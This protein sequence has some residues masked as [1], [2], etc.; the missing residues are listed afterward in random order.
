MYQI[1]TKK[2]LAPKIKLFEVE[3]PEIAEKTKP[4]QFLIVMVQEKGERVPLTI[5]DFD[6]RKGSVTFVFNEVGKSTKQLGTL[7]VGDS[8]WNI[9]GPLGVPSEMKCFGNVLCVGGGVLIAPL[10]LQVKVLKSLGNHVTAVVGARIKDLLI[11]EKEVG[12]Y[13]DEIYLTTDDGSKGQTGLGFVKGLADKTKF[14]RCIAMGPVAML[15]EIC[16]ITKAHDVPTTV[17]LLPIMIDGMGMCGVCRV[18]VGGKMKFACVD[19]PEFDGH[20][21]D[22][23]ELIKRQRMFLPEERLSSLWWELQG[24]CRCDR[25]E[26]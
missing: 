16:E 1:L 19:G 18:S 7:N 21:V 22:F 9:T 13:A 10:M 8:V 6:T 3:A 24:G 11:C 5:A 26:A 17:T 12:Q 2:E 25:T 15:K 23:E 14:D 20:Q 4:G